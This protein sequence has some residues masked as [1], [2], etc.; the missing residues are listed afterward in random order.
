MPLSRFQGNT[1]YSVIA[2]FANPR[3][4][5]TSDSCG[6]K[7]SVTTVVVISPAVTSFV[8]L[9]LVP[10]ASVD[11]SALNANL[12]ITPLLPTTVTRVSS[13][14]KATHV[15]YLTYTHVV[16]VEPPTSSPAVAAESDKGTYFYAVQSGS[17]VWLNDKTPTAT[18]GLIY[19]TTTVVVSP[20]PTSESQSES[21]TTSTTVLKK[22]STTF[23]TVT[24]T[25]VTGSVSSST[26][27][28]PGYGSNGWN[29]T[30]SSL[31][32]TAI[33]PTGTGFDKPEQTIYKPTVTISTSQVAGSGY[34]PVGTVKPYRRFKGKR[35]PDQWIT[36]T[37]NDQVFSWISPETPSPS[38]EYGYG[39]APTPTPAATPTQYTI[40]RLLDLASLLEKLNNKQASSVNAVVAIASPT[41]SEPTYVSTQASTTSYQPSETT[42]T[43]DTMTTVASSVT[44]DV[45]STDLSTTETSMAYA[46]ITETSTTETSTTE[47][48]S[49]YASPIETSTTETST[50]ETTSTV[51]STESGTANTTQTPTTVIQQLET[52]GT[53]ATSVTT[54]AAASPSSCGEYGN[55]TLDVSKD[56][57]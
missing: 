22:T 12:D 43:A 5:S 25:Q 42:A 51:T 20:V 2:C 16:T 8:T 19:G 49:A 4:N 29:S 53:S 38:S 32:G 11:V 44:G 45:V 31:Q 14:D 48:S 57:L 21:T 50:T 46:S 30:T 34:A 18:S 10:V 52:V 9:D 28:Y 41:A 56:A 33:G 3:T 54:S 7:V 1:I 26:R 27:S 36:A 35:A 17:T 13:G 6:A 47:T 24:T 15:T 55:F 37:V 23:V 39:P 40:T